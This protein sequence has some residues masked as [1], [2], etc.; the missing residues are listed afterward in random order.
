MA[1]ILI[2]LEQREEDDQV[3]MSTLARSLSLGVVKNDQNEHGYSS[4][5][6]AKYLMISNNTSFPTFHS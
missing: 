6:N 1:H 3:V 4:D 2:C 5:N